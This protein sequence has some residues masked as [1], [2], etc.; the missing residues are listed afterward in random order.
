MGFV[1]V[2]STGV[3]EL[4][5][6]V[7]WQMFGLLTG[8]QAMSVAKDACRGRTAAELAPAAARAIMILLNCILFYFFGILFCDDIFVRMFLCFFLF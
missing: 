8:T 5:E 7:S 3:P 1:A 6:K 2:M 4:V